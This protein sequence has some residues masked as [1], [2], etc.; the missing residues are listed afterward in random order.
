MFENNKTTSCDQSITSPQQETILA[1]FS[2]KRIKMQIDVHTAD[3]TAHATV[4]LTLFHH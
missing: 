2:N 1:K 4:F 3:K